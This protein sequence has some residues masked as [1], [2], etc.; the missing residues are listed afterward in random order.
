MWT[1]Q[2]DESGGR[3]MWTCQ[4]DWSRGQVMRSYVVYFF[5]QLIT[6][7]LFHWFMFEDWKSF[8]AGKF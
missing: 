5:G 3:V 8:L 4:E 2:E 7:T 1:G 6:L